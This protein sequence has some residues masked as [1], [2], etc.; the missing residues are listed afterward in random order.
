MAGK[1]KVNVIYIYIHR[2]LK[3]ESKGYPIRR[4]D[5]LGKIFGMHFHF[6]KELRPIILD[7]LE[8]LGMIKLYGSRNCM[9]KVLS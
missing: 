3:E 4:E 2:K 9:I 8:K 1:K 7:D 6:P 5:V